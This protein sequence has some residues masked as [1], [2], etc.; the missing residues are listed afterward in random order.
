MMN[1]AHRYAKINEGGA[2]YYDSSYEVLS[3]DYANS[4]T[5]RFFGDS[6]TAGEVQSFPAPTY[7]FNATYH[8]PYY[9]GGSLYW[10]AADGATT[11]DFVVVDSVLTFP[12]GHYEMTFIKYELLDFYDS[13]GGLAVTEYYYSMTPGQAASASELNQIGAGSASVYPKYYNGH[14]SYELIRYQEY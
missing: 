8:G 9:S 1:F 11:T 13:I 5:E 4:I 10:D 2:V 6:V 12:D 3:L 7:S 14:D